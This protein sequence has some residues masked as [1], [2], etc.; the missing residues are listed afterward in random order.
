MPRH[1]LQTQPPG[2]RK[3]AEWV[4]WW[5]RVFWGLITLALV[6]RSS[7]P[8]AGEPE[9]AKPTASLESRAASHWAFRPLQRPTLPPATTP[10]SLAPVDVFVAHRLAEIGL[11]AGPRADRPALIRRVSFILTGLPPTPEE[12]RAFIE[13]SN[14]GAYGNLVER[15][16]ASP[17]YGERWGQHW[18]EAA[19]YADSNGYF[20]ADT[21]RPLAYRYRDFV[22]RSLNRDKPFDQFV[23]EQ[24]AGDELAAWQPGQPASP[25]IIELLEAT[26]YLRNG[27]DGSGESDGNPD[28]VRT[29]RY[30]ALESAEQIIGSSLLGVT[31]Q[32]AKCHDHKFE[33][34]TQKDYYSLQAFL[35]PAFHI[36][37][38]IKPND[39]IV[40][41]PLPGQHEAWK[42]SETLLDAEESATRT[43]FREWIRTA[44]P[45]GRLLFADDF[46]A[47]Q[48]LA[49]NWSHTAPGDDQPGGIPPV[50]LD[51]STPPA[52]R[53]RGDALDIL[54]GGGSGDRWISTRQ[55]FDWR[56][57]NQ[58]QWIQVTFDLVATRLDRDGTPAERI[59]YLL[60][61]HDFNDNSP[62]AG[63]NLLL[64]GNPGGATQVQVDYPGP[65]AR[66]RGTIGT[67]GCQAGHN[68]G[69]RITRAGTNQLSLE[70][71]VDGAPDGSPVTLS[72]E[73]LPPGGF[74]FEYCCGRSFTVDRVAIEASD[75]ANPAWVERQSAFA[76][77]LRLRKEA[78]ERATAA[79]K[80]RRQ[81]EPGRIAWM[82]DVSAEAPA[83]PLLKRGNHKTPGETVD[84]DV[85]TFLKTATLGAVTPAITKTS[86]T[87][88]RRLALARWLTL[89]DSPQSALLARV[90][91]NRVWQQYFGT[92]IA[93][94]PDNL[95]LSGALPSNPEL[96]EWLAAAFADSGWSLKSLHRA[97]LHSATFQQSASPRPEGI[98]RDP[99]NLRLWRYPLHRLDAEAIRDAMLAVSD[100]LGTKASG[101]YVPTPRR[102]DGE[103]VPDEKHPEAHS[104]SVFLQH[105]R[106]QV[107]TFAATFDAPSLVFNCTRRATTTMPLQSLSLLNSEFTVRRGQDLAQR[108][109]RECGTDV[110]GGI[111]R[112]FLLTCGREPDRAELDATLKFL[113][114]QRAA[115]AGRPDAESL[116]WADLA[117][118]L[119]G[120][121]AF[122]YLE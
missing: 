122:L 3:T 37:Q 88:G 94:T 48:T 61:L 59:G 113:A 116:A 68:Y 31:L 36:E 17:H 62:V 87:T 9:A 83:V 55:A 76:K 73:D 7:I 100:Q 107:P 24:L 63:G 69:V 78:L 12:I 60:A 65:D 30:Y 42:A 33:P 8:A 95:G 90:T 14:P 106:T 70:P 11:T 105:R 43:A 79:V 52:A 111:R 1:R 66:S 92:G 93:A 10:D 53:I 26:H 102:A 15:L 67:T 109:G 119:F 112:G 85:P 80:T 77:E 104:R 51:G 115:Y 35:Y 19:G 23:R 56:P 99:S 86:R 108:I 44:Q 74:G 5:R 47:G 29:D 21:D 20:N 49:A 32:C 103:V 120:L 114:R 16:L 117:Q 46:N 57:A 40:S 101:P 89:P 82:S 28:E 13:D 64:D 97:I 81:P 39:R 110:E 38:W 41:A 50:A 18:L 96:L 118:S 2:T 6:G 58:G 98:A 22:L 84:A 121:N 27:Q 4:A 34:V 54:E 91:V 45:P 71:L 25:E 72:D 75:D